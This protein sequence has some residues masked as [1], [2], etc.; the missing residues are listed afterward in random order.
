LVTGVPYFRQAGVHHNVVNV[1]DHE[2][3]FVEVE[4]RP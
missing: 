3:V 4:F 1:N 2:F